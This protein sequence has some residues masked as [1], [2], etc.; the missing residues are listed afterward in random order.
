MVAMMAA[1]AN[2]RIMVFLPERYVGLMDSSVRTPLQ[3][4]RLPVAECPVKARPMEQETTFMLLAAGVG[5]TQNL[6]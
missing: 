6:N 4:G 1:T 3:D 5:K 2:E